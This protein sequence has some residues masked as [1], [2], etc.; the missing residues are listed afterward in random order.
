VYLRTGVAA[1]QIVKIDSSGILKL[2]AGNGE[3]G[4][5]GDG[6]PALNAQLYGLGRIRTDAAGNIY[7]AEGDNGIRKISVDGTISTIVGSQDLN[8][9]I[10]LSKNEVITGVD[11]LSVIFSSDILFLAVGPDGSVFFAESARDMVYQLT[12]DGK[13]ST[14]AGDG[15]EGYAGDGGPATAAKFDTI[16]GLAVDASGNVYVSEGIRD[17]NHIRK[18]TRDTPLLTGGGTGNGTG[19]G[20][21]TG[22]T[23]F[24]PGGSISTVAGSGPN[25]TGGFT[26]DGS[27]ATEAQ[28]NR[29]G[30]FFVTLSGD[31]YLSDT[32][33]HRIRRI[34]AATGVIE[35]IA[36]NGTET[37]SAET[38]PAISADIPS[39]GGIFVDAA[40]NVFVASSNR[41]I[42][43]DT[44]GTI[45]T[46]AGNGNTDTFHGD[47]GP[48]T[49]ASLFF[50][51]SIVV[52][53]TGNI[54]ICDTNNHRI[55]RVDAATG[56]ISTYAGNGM[57]DASGFSGTFAGDG[58]PATDASF[59]RPSDIAMDA[60]ENLFVM[61]RENNRLRKIDAT[62]GIVS[63]IAG[64]GEFSYSGDGGPATDAT[65]GAPFGVHV[66]AAGD[67]FITD[68]QNLRIRMIDS[69]GIITS[70][71]G[72]GNGGF[73][74]AGFDGDSNASA[75][76][77]KFNFPFDAATD[78]AGNL[79]VLDPNNHRVRKVQTG[80]GTSAGGG[81]TGGGDTGGTTGSTTVL[82]TGTRGPMA[83]DLDK[84]AGDQMVLQTTTAPKAGDTI[85]VD[86]ILTEG[87]S[88]LS[89]YEMTVTF[90]AA[91]LEF[92]NYAT[93]DVF[94]GA[95]PINTS[96]EGTFTSSVVFFGA[97]TTSKAAGS[98]GTITFTVLAEFTGETNITLTKASLATPSPVAVEIGPG[99]SFVVIGGV[100]ATAY[101][102]EPVART[103]FSGD[104]EIGF[105]DFIT[106]ATAFGKGSAD[107]DFDP[108][109]DLNDNGS[110]DF[111]DFILFA[112]LFGQKVS[113]KP[114]GKSIGQY[115][116]IN[117]DA[118]LSLL[119]QAGDKADYVTL[120]VSLSDIQ[121]VLAYNLT[122]NYDPSALHLMRAETAQ[123]SRLAQSAGLQP[124]VLQTLL[125]DG[126]L[127]LSDVFADPI[128][129]EG[130]LLD[131]TFQ[132]SNP[133]AIG[134]IEISN[135]LIADPDGNINALQ[136]AR[137]TDLNP[138]PSEFALRQNH[139]NP[140]NPETQIGYQ[141]PLAGE[142]SITVYNLLG[143]E[144][145]QLVNDIKAAGFYRVSW[146]GQD[147]LGRS[148][149]SG[150][151]FYRIKAGQFSQTKM[152][153]LLK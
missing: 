133:D 84:T 60:A 66:G 43:I 107:A 79:Y 151:Y 135:V 119:P 65:L 97:T 86:V 39:P 18:L 91:Q 69:A 21:T 19:T 10:R 112:Q 145:R 85:T 45:S 96:G 7:V 26:G 116:G 105:S 130:A 55:R 2:V 12:P 49:A 127:I 120:S 95:V 106:F 140:F 44:N 81:D 139:P 78:A 67:I 56:V 34:T 29:P 123:P 128:Q 92:S 53:A 59:N 77:A 136:G 100:A 73:E 28:L 89:G 94:S 87:G 146:N 80:S 62:T 31:I 152:M 144:V 150:I 93:T 52:D 148:V 5:A 23:A 6:G 109:I 1:P 153:I 125:D 3:R 70:V 51:S 143:Q 15:T 115:F 37:F 27:A 110:V 46:V 41:V 33:N 142:V 129:Y 102:T 111:A 108:R 131:I 13:V 24:L 36:G 99:G 138:V 35:T 42:K 82:P 75:L 22:A 124:V 98:I 40:G 72:S 61:D 63:T 71:A 137:L 68:T 14:I 83:L 57:L 38:G 147:A 76:E 8:T 103:D 50:P 17:A 47:G 114:A 117:T 48:A 134:G 132:V 25:D 149:G 101:P 122:L 113:G 30:G 90:D 32:A 4:Q 11:P 118:V 121:E 104:G 9:G 20:G 54:F 58:G 16:W 126:S 64:N 88:G 141:L 74:A